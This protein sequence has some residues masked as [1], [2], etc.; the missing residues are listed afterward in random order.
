MAGLRYEQICKHKESEKSLVESN[1]AQL[2]RINE[3][4]Q[5]Y[6][7][8]LYADEIEFLQDGVLLFKELSV[9]LKSLERQKAGAVYG[10]LR[11]WAEGYLDKFLR[12]NPNIYQRVVNEFRRLAS[13]PLPAQNS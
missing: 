10:D 13:I 9:K 4:L 3:Q 6:I 5:K 12:K 8:I 11:S 7:V 1:N 2:I